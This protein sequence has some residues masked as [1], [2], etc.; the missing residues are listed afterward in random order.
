MIPNDVDA[1]TAMAESRP[2]HSDALAVSSQGAPEADDASQQA[3]VHEIS[4]CSGPFITHPTNM[5]MPSHGN[6]RENGSLAQTNGDGSDT[7]EASGPPATED[8][9]TQ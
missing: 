2:S 3:V 4:S 5:G 8:K 9:T 7:N 1:P 6:E